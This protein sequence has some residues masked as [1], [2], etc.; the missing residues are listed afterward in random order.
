M[1]NILKQFV[2]LVTR[3]KNNQFLWARLRLSSYYAMIVFTII[4]VFSFAVYG[5]FMKDFKSNLEYKGEGQEENLNIELEII[6]K[7]EDRLQNTIK[8]FDGLILL[9]I[10]ISSYYLSGKILKPV[11]QSYQRQKKFVADI[12][13]ELRTPLAIMKIG[14]ETVLAGDS[15]KKEYE[16]MIKDFLEETNFLSSVVDDLL[17]L[18][19]S[20]DSS[21]IELS[22]FSFDELIHKQVG[23]MKSYALKKKVII[24]DNIKEKVKINGNKE[25]LKRLLVN[26]IKNAIDYNNP[27]GEVKLE[28]QKNKQLIEL[29]IS[30]TGIGI[31][32]ED[33]NHI[34]DRFYKADQAR[35]RETGGA[36]LGLSIV[37]EIVLLHHG[38]I[39]I[40]SEV[41]RG[42]EIL[43]NLPLISS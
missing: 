37:Q 23:L 28:L 33:L 8:I 43:I 5:F 36:G 26:L 18:V 31:N 14:A 42:T 20:N 27:H 7:A 39:N 22:N 11:E 38:T 13:H 15:S 24:H 16:I 10:I 2:E 1:K 21:K 12:A 34:F 41:G 29:K 35:A 9:L 32:K 17:F 40:E 25:Y 3:F 19:G 4:L 30:D 6:D